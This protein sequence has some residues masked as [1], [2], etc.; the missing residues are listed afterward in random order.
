MLVQAKSQ[1]LPRI[2]NA[3]FEA[4][5]CKPGEDLAGLLSSL[6]ALRHPAAREPCRT[7]ARASQCREI[8]QQGLSKDS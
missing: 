4:M 2:L 3:T 7:P 8:S 1:L 5:K 6:S